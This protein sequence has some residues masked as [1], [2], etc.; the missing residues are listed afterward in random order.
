MLS[1]INNNFTVNYYGV[2]YD[3]LKV[4]TKGVI[5]FEDRGYVSGSN[6]TMPSTSL[7]D[8][9]IAAFWDDISPEKKCRNLID[10]YLLNFPNLEYFFY[11]DIVAP[12][13]RKTTA[14]EFLNSFSVFILCQIL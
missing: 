1:F 7:P 14:H 8:A 5:T 2:D 9:L 6:Q 4:G 13:S 12:S 10:S 3:S 11:C